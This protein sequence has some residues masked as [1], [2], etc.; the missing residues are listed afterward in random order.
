[1]YR[2]SEA[3]PKKRIQIVSKSVSK[4]YQKC[5]DQPKSVSK[6]VSI[7]HKVY[8]KVYQKCIAAPARSSKSYRNHIEISYR[9][10]IEIFLSFYLKII[11]T[12]IRFDTI[13]KPKRAPG[14]VKGTPFKKIQ[15]NRPQNTLLGLQI[16]S[17]LYRE[18]VSKSYRDFPQFAIEN[19]RNS[20]TISIRFGGQKEAPEG[21]LKGPGTP[22]KDP[23]GNHP[24]NTFLGLQIVSK[25]YREIV[26]KSY[27]DFPQFAIEN[28]RNSDTISLRFGGQ[29]EAPQGPLKDPWD[30]CQGPP[31]KPPPKHPPGA[32]NRIEIVSRNRI[33]IVSEF[34]LFSIA[35]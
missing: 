1:M 11:G 14:R 18:I 10:R 16:V 20:D 24:Q 27:R 8:R 15:E 9:N 22:A 19:S 12:G 4:V 13:W 5:I 7:G 30:P 34:L 32:P 25:S 31:K 17:K 23:P 6:S 21:P 35:N 33:E 3:V 28:S 26:S 29:K 2:P